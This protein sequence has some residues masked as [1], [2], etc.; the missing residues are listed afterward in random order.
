MKPSEFLPSFFAIDLL[1]HLRVKSLE[2]NIKSFIIVVSIA[3][4]FNQVEVTKLG[5]ERGTFPVVG[6]PVVGFFNNWEKE[7]R[8]FPVAPLWQ[9]PIPTALKRRNIP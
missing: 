4:W 1:G 2:S 3:V 9:I 8:T 7:R 6:F 5:K